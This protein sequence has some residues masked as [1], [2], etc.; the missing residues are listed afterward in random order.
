MVFWSSAWRAD[1]LAKKWGVSNQA[2]L[3]NYS[4]AQPSLGRVGRR[5]TVVLKWQRVYKPFANVYIGTQTFSH[6]SNNLKSQSSLDQNRFITVG[7]FEI[8]WFLG[9]QVWV[10]IARC[11]KGWVTHNVWI[12]L[13]G[14]KSV[15]VPLLTMTGLSRK[16][17][18]VC[19][20]HPVCQFFASKKIDFI[21]S[22]ITDY[23]QISNQFLK[24]SLTQF[25]LLT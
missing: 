24:P 3:M 4:E 14:S 2:S 1:W 9:E 17:V 16:I 22:I 15:R 7:S 8:G 10:L 18:F 25:N 23:N 6:F 11:A 13:Y 12:T 19:Y 20:Q 5:K 21:S